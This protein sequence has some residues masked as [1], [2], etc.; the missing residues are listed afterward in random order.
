[1]QF[2]I[3]KRI[4]YDLGKIKYINYYCNDINNIVLVVGKIV[5]H[6]KIIDIYDAHDYNLLC[7]YQME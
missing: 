2:N 1:M 3:V 5:D 7:Q 4:V 6:E